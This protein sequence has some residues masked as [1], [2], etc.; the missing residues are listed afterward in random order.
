[1]QGEMEC[2]PAELVAQ[3]VNQAELT[4]R[5]AIESK[6]LSHD[7]RIPFMYSPVWL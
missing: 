5:Y 7:S 6:S 2:V 3:T 4:G 1:M